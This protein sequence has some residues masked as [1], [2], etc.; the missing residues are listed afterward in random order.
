MSVRSKLDNE[1]NATHEGLVQCALHIGRQN[2][3]AAVGL[4]SLQQVVDLDICIAIV[5]VFHLAAFAK[6]R[7]RLVKK[8]NRAAILG[9]VKQAP[10]VLLRFADVFT[11]N[12]R[13]IDAKQVET[14]MIG[15]D[16]RSH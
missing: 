15:D 13:E 11:Y 12:R 5:A 2:R 10:Q 1:T 9:S 8:E 6:Q 7:I 14:Q 4:D 3:Q 16:F